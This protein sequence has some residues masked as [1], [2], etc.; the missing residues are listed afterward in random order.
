MST[1]KSSGGTFVEGYNA[2]I[3]VPVAIRVAE[4]YHEI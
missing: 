2:L 1:I 3:L 4:R